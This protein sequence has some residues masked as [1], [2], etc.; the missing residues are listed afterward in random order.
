MS[1]AH[2]L[3]G[4][5]LAPEVFSSSRLSRLSTLF[6]TLPVWVQAIAVYFVS[7]VVS[8]SI[9]AAVLKRQDP[10]NW[11]SSPVTT[12]LNDF[13]NFWDGGWYG[14]VAKEGYPNILP[15]DETGAVAENQWA[16]YPLHPAIVG[17]LSSVTGLSYEV[18]SPIVSTLAAGLAAIVILVLFRRYVDPGQALTGLALVMFFPRR[19]SSPPGTRSR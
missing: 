8:I 16:F 4:I 1:K 6:L 12:T 15:I 18:I 7:R 5:T 9:F 19:P 2:D 14:R 11:S 17:N 10:A 13:L 3:P